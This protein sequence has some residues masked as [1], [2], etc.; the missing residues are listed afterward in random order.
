MRF[1][2]F[3]L[4]LLAALLGCAHTPTART[5]P[6][7]ADRPM[8]PPTDFP[9]DENGNVL[10]LMAAHGDDLT[11]ARVVDFGH[12]LPDEAAARRM[13]AAAVQLGFAVQ[14][15]PIDDDELPAGQRA[16]E[17]DVTCSQEMVPTHAGI[18][19]VERQLDALARSFGGRADGWG[20]E[21]FD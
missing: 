4:L 9:A 16:G 21:T 18:T 11:R 2:S 12:L 14:V 10:R 3:L 15:E 6:I 13:A 20:C 19:A 1:A 8:R 17:W 7:L 5:D